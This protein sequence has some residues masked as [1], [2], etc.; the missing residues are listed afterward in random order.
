AAAA[1]DDPEIGREDEGNLGAAESGLLEQQRSRALPEDGVLMRH[2]MVP[3]PDKPERLPGQRSAVSRIAMFP[4]PV[5]S[6]T[7]PWPSPSTACRWLWLRLC[8][9][10]ATGSRCTWPRFVFASTR[11]D[12]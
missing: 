5:R 2:A 8:C 12:T 9:P 11:A 6:R 10:P 3:L 4:T 1:I 7:E